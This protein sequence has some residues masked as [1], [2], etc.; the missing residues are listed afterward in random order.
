MKN[1]EKKDAKGRFLPGWS[2]GPG[3]GKK[4]KTVINDILKE[5]EDVVIKG[6][7]S[8]DLSNR[9]KA[10]GLALK[11]KSIMGPGSDDS[12]TPEEMAELKEFL[13]WKM[14]QDL[15]EEAKEAEEDTKDHESVK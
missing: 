10:A 9:L 6:M 14:Q 11:L 4:K 8:G 3:R 5:I 2:G 7:R 13:M 15:A 12:D 1:G